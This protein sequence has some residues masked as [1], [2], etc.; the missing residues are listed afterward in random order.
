VAL[1]VWGA[2]ATSASR[3]AVRDLA[4]LRRL[5]ALDDAT[6]GVSRAAN[7]SEPTIAGPGGLPRLPPT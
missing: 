7:S 2:L 4:R 6:P 3:G 5:E 1:R